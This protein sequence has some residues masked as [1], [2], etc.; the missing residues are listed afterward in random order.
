MGPLNDSPPTWVW[1]SS[2]LVSSKRTL[3]SRFSQA[4]LGT[5]IIWPSLW[6]RNRLIFLLS[7][8]TFIMRKLM[9]W[10][11]FVTLQTKHS[12]RMNVWPDLPRL[13]SSVSPDSPGVPPARWASAAQRGA[14]AE[15]PQL[16]D[17]PPAAMPERQT[18]RITSF[19]HN[20]S[21]LDHLS[22]WI[23]KCLNPYLQTEADITGVFLVL[24]P[25]RQL[26]HQ[27]PSW[28]RGQCFH[29]GGVGGKSGEIF[30]MPHNKWPD[31]H[32]KHK[33]AFKCMKKTIYS[34]TKRRPCGVFLYSAFNISLCTTHS[35]CFSLHLAS[36][37]SAVLVRARMSDSA[38]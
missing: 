20:P 4:S 35:L 8:T 16:R 18:V 38:L 2:S 6:K 27:I 25:S 32:L 23:L 13:R 22:P 7:C 28:F 37:R 1:L 10:S 14:P 15:L 12:Q 21:K 36:V 5:V 29:R 33:D 24:P 30:C 9:F 34:L 31:T 3:L 19:N 26:S 17:A 11:L